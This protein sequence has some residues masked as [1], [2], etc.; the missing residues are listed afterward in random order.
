[1]R[2]AK[3][4]WRGASAGAAVPRAFDGKGYCMALFRIMVH[5]THFS[6]IIS[7]KELYQSGISRVM[8]Q[9]IHGRSDPF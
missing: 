5:H 6:R 2:G 1:M 3:K 4:I 7:M 9:E 8:L